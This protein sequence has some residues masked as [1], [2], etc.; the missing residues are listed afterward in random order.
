MM[1]D[2]RAHFGSAENTTD[3]RP[4]RT[5]TEQNSTGYKQTYRHKNESRHACVPKSC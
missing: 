2:A 3:A 1:I 4:F 5:S